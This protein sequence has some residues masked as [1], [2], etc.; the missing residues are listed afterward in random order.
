VTKL[1]VGYGDNSFNSPS[2]HSCYSE[3]LIP[4]HI[5]T[6]KGQRGCYIPN[7]NF[8]NQ[9]AFYLQSHPNLKWIKTNTV[10]MMKLPGTLKIVGIHGFRFMFGR[11]L[12]DGQYQLGKVYA[13][14]GIYTFVTIN[15]GRN[16][17][18]FEVLT[19]EKSNDSITTSSTLSNENSNDAV[20]TECGIYFIY[21]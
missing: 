12:Y 4:C 20:P 15:F 1:Y 17:D 19:C 7:G 13:G 18:S 16:I 11:A 14:G 5:I 10:D 9:T 3:D 2:Y 21:H 8:D 6:T